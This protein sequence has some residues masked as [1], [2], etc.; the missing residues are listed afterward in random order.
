MSRWLIHN[1]KIKILAVVLALIIWLYFFAAREG[2][3]FTAGKIKK[4]DVAVEVLGLPLSTSSIKVDPNCIE[5]T[6]KGPA[7]IISFLS[8]EDLK[9]FVE[10]KGLVK[11]H[12]T[13]PVRVYTGNR[14]DIIS[15]NPWTVTAIID[16]PSLIK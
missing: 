12:Y 11:G 6:V 2:I 10:V 9:V 7:R 8:P 16:S 14:V 3:S 1:I 15:K 13:L 4:M 5:V